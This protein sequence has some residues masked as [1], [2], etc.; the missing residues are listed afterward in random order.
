M[1][2]QTPT[3]SCSYDTVPV[4]NNSNCFTWGR[5]ACPGPP[6]RNPVPRWLRGRPA[7]LSSEDP[8]PTPNTV[9]NTRIHT[10]TRTRSSES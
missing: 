7:L 10:H 1:C 8:T 3:R 2:A 5:A 4:R 9:H 6:G